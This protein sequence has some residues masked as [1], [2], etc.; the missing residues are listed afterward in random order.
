M[1]GLSLKQIIQIFWEGKRLALTLQVLGF[2]EVK[3]VGGGPL[4]PPSPFLY[5]LF[6]RNQIVNKDTSDYP[7]SNDDNIFDQI[8]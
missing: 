4:D 2:L 5:F 1:K 8:S 6:S 7:A 3:S